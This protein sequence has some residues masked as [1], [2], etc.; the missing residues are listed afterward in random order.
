M[1]KI[2]FVIWSANRGIFTHVMMNVL[3]FSEKGYDVGV[4][5]ES[6]GCKLVSAYEEDK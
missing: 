5:F 6:E 3:D 1:K 2:L 4:V